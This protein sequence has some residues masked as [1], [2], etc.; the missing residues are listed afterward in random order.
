MVDR[1]YDRA[2]GELTTAAKGLP[3]DAIAA[4]FVA[5]VHRRRGDWAKALEE[6]AA[7]LELDPRNATVAILLGETYSRLRRYREADR[8]FSL[9]ISLTPDHSDGY[10]FKAMNYWFWKGETAEARRILEEMPYRTDAERLVWAWFTQETL[11][12]N[13]DAALSRLKFTPLASFES[14]L[15]FYPKALLSALT[16][17][18]LDRSEEARAAV[19]RCS[20][21]SGTAGATESRRPSPPLCARHHVCRPRTQG[22]SGRRWKT[23]RGAHASFEGRNGG[24]MADRRFSSHLHDGGRT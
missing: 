8:A 18:E 19:R 20:G 21:F 3:N 12:R 9:G 13:F 4:A 24:A 14:Q 5:S 22:R 17:R 11:E 7:A 16:L 1:D 2:L 15:S 23:R 6:W 10:W